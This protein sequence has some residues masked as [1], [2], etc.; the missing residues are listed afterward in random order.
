MK[1]LV[2]KTILI[3]VLCVIGVLALTFFAFF[4][5][6][7]KVL[8]N[9]FKSLGDDPA[10]VYF[11]EK[12]YKKTD[13]AED[14]AVIIDMYDFKDDSQ[15]VLS[16]SQELVGKSDFAEFCEK[17]DAGNTG[18]TTS[19]Y[20]YAKY[21]V[22]SYYEGNINS[23]VAVCKTSVSISGYT[24]YNAFRFLL[25]RVPLNVIEKTYVKAELTFLRFSLSAEEQK[26]VDRD[27]SILPD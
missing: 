14:L 6:A 4:L 1:K 11:Y 3:T 16:L 22:A 26:I 25:S 24:E 18:I 15:K 9:A 20:Y 5:F 10:A 19:E 2:I 12:Q 17:K 13:S 27:M 8:G 23:A 21:A 7:P